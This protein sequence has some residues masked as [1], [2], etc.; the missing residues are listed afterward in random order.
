MTLIERINENA[1]AAMRERD[2][3]KTDAL[4]MLKTAIKRREVDKRGALDDAEILQTIASLIKQ[5]K[6]SIDIYQKANRTDLADRERREIEILSS[7][8]PDQ[9]SKEELTS[10]IDAVIAEMEASSPKDMGRVMKAVMARVAGKADGKLVSEL[11]KS[12]LS[13]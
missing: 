5:R 12:R 11:V 1:K 3:V 2:Q 8:M 9:L 10:T 4:R 7:F 13:V 6:E